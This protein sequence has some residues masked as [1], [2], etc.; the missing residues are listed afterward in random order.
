[1]AKSA[2]HHDSTGALT[3][4]ASIK[5]RR[6]EISLYPLLIKASWCPNQS[7]IG[8]PATFTSLPIVPGQNKQ[9]SRSRFED[10]CWLKGQ[11]VFEQ[12]RN[13]TSRWH[14]SRHFNFA[15]WSLN[16]DL[17]SLKSMRLEGQRKCIGTKRAKTFKRMH[18]FFK[19]NIDRRDVK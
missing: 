6:Q 14:S 8:Q 12:P 4:N 18:F 16:I 13:K 1:M 10:K 5:N 17:G 11:A 15:T 19:A 7:C 9:H 2:L 3:L